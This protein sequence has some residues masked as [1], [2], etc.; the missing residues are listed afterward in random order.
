[1]FQVPN[2]NRIRRG[3]HKSTEEAGNNGAFFLEQKHALALI[4]FPGPGM[5]NIK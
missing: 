5:G 4:G 1:M 2:E 3:S